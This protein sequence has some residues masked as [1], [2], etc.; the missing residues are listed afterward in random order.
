MDHG[1]QF[2]QSCV[3]RDINSDDLGYLI[4]WYMIN[5]NDLDKFFKIVEESCETNFFD[6]SKTIGDLIKNYKKLNIDSAKER[7]NYMRNQA[8]TVFELTK[9]FTSEPTDNAMK[10]ALE[11]A[12]YVLEL[13]N[14]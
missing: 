5:I 1:L 13:T 6:R 14:D 4:K 11:M 8:V 7:R 9:G 2:I 12:G 3:R 10:T